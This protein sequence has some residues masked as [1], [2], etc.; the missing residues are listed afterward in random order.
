MLATVGGSAGTAAQPGARPSAPRSAL[1]NSWQDLIPLF[2]CLGQ[3]PGQDPIH[4]LGQL[5]PPPPHRRRRLRQ[6]GH[7]HRPVVLAFERR[8]PGQ[9]VVGHA[10]QRVLI[11]AP[12]YRHVLALFRRGIIGG[13][14]ELTSPVS[15]VDLVACLLKPKSDRYT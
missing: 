3:G 4:C 6:V 14:E 1:A 13:P 5:R 11:G 7:E 2:R 10:R 8:R 15:V 9:Q 12:V